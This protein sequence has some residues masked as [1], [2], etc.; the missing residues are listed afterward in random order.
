MLLRLTTTE[1]L[2]DDCP[3]CE[4][5]GWLVDTH[6]HRLV[7]VLQQIR[8]HPDTPTTARLHLEIDGDDH[9]PTP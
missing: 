7:T 9:D 8:R 5:R 2:P 1:T 3:L 4:Q 6:A